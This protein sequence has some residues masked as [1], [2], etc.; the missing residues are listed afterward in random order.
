ML[1]VVRSPWMMPAACMRPTVRPMRVSSGS[2]LS[3]SL[4]LLFVWL[5]LWLS[6][7]LSLVGAE[8]RLSDSGSGPGSGSGSSE[9]IFRASC[10]SRCW[11]TVWPGIH[12]VKIQP[13][14]RVWKLLSTGSNSKQILLQF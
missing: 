14:A 11:R 8:L 4:L 13:A 5:F 1:L 10:S 3:V 2:R 6:L 9:V 12:S 7:S